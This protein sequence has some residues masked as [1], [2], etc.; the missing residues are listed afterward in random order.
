MIRL[1]G[2][3]GIQKASDNPYENGK[4]Q[5]QFAE[6]DPYEIA[7]A[8]KKFGYSAAFCPA[9]SMND[10]ARIK[11]IREAF[12]LEDVMIA[13]VGAWRNLIDQD[14]QR[15]QQ[16]LDFVCDKLAAA[17]EVGAKCCVDFIGSILSNENKGLPM[18]PFDPHPFNLSEEGFELTVETV[19][20]II[21]AVKPKRTKFALEFMQW[22]LPDSAESCLELIR[23]VDRPQ[24]A[25]HMDPC[26]IIL[27]PRQY[28]DN[29]AL[30]RN[31]FQ[32]LGPYIVSCHA[33]DLHMRSQ[34]ALHLDEVIPGKGVLDYRTFLTE[35]DKLPG[36]IPLLLEHLNI[37]EE[38]AQGRDYIVSVGRD[39]GVNF[40][41][42]S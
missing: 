32:L 33:K 29:G 24:F 28:F 34:L 13:E 41:S 27:T 10:M 21:D 30:I 19:R 4:N 31:A 37:S 12:E 14:L 15:R 40:Y 38:Y 23:A 20:N 18:L 16:N 7:R 17:E 26:N 11:E 39:V 35:I 9:V 6:S 5:K 3:M 25:A 1:G 42:Y 2:G 22:Q 8:H 36:Q